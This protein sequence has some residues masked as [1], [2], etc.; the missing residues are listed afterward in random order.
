MAFD[1]SGP[2][3]WVPQLGCHTWHQKICIIHGTRFRVTLVHETTV[4]TNAELAPFVPRDTLRF[5]SVHY[6]RGDLRH[7]LGLV[8]RF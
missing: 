8:A 7:D 6:T 2:A 5:R 4:P 1:L 3:L